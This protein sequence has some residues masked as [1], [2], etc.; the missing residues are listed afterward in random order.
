[1]LYAPNDYLIN[2]FSIMSVTAFLKG[3]REAQARCPA[4]NALISKSP[5]ISCTHLFCGDPLFLG[6]LALLNQTKNLWET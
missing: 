4:S 6:K 1:M 5:V 3:T 2:S